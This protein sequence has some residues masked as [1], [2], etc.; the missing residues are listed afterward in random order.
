MGAPRTTRTRALPGSQG[1]YPRRGGLQ[2]PPGRPVSWRLLVALCSEPAAEEGRDSPTFSPPQHLQAGL[3]L[4]GKSLGVMA[5]SQAEGPQQATGNQQLQRL[6]QFSISGAG[7]RSS[8]GRLAVGWFFREGECLR[9]RA[10]DHCIWNP[11][12]G[13]S[14]EDKKTAAH[15]SPLMDPAA[16]RT[17]GPGIH[18]DVLRWRWG[19]RAHL[20]LNFR[21]PEK[22]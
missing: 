1:L 10:L 7:S 14:P 5:R 21:S 13:V 4:Q 18:P 20:C 16:L 19:N 17:R 9:R 8:A 2:I 15:G 3:S 12:G 22:P 6:L 11:G